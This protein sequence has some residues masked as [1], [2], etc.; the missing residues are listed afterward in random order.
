MAWDYPVVIIGVFL[1]AMLVAWA[2][3]RLASSP[4]ADPTFECDVCGRSQIILAAR[5]WRY[6]PYCGVPRDSRDLRDLPRRKSVL[7]IEP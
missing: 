7:D 2:I 6:C 4:K 3:L 1:F 5:E